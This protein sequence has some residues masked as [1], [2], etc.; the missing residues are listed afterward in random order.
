[1]PHRRPLVPP[2]DRSNEPLDEYV[3]ETAI[4]CMADAEHI[5]DILNI[6]TRLQCPEVRPLLPLADTKGC[7]V[8]KPDIQTVY[9]WY[10]SDVLG[11]QACVRIGLTGRE[12]ERPNDYLDGKS[13]GNNKLKDYFVKQ[14]SID[15]A[16]FRAE[17]K[18]DLH[19]GWTDLQLS[20]IPLPVEKSVAKRIEKALIA[21]YK[22]EAN[23]T[24]HNSTAYNSLTPTQQLVVRKGLEKAPR[25]D[26]TFGGT[27]VAYSVNAIDGPR[28]R[29]PA[30]AP[31]YAGDSDEKIPRRSNEHS[32]TSRSRDDFLRDRIQLAIGRDDLTP[33]EFRS[34]IA[35]LVHDGKFIEDEVKATLNPLLQD[36]DRL[37]DDE[38]S[39]ADQYAQ[40]LDAVTP[41]LSQEADYWLACGEG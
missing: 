12:L 9:G 35:Y 14:C 15:A 4:P 6:I 11:T 21:M 40:R 30:Y 17:S 29:I 22:P 5:G 39:V 34:S 37:R 1:M 2:K 33:D 8:I 25:V 10:D 18:G 36:L 23:N 13:V 38:T 41:T 31:L 26:V 32:A 24:D 19:C 27:Y 28:D 16:Q 20:M 7:L 3:L